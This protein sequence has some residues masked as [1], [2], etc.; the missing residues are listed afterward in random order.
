MATLIHTG[1]WHLGR[2]LHGVRLIEDQAYILDELVA[3]VERVKPDAL[4]IAGDVYDRSVPPAEAVRLL[5]HFLERVVRDLDTRVV[6]ISGNH[7][8]AERIGFGA[9]ILESGK[10]HMRGPLTDPIA[11][12]TIEDEHG[13]LDLFPLPF[14]EPARVRDVLNEET[15]IDHPSAMAAMLRRIL[16]T[17]ADRRRVLIAHAFVSGGLVSDSER[18]LTIGG[19]ETVDTQL[20]DDFQYVA[21]GHLHRPQR[22][23]HDRIQY[24]G[25][26]LKYSF[27]EVDQPKSVS[28]VHIDAQGDVRIE[29]E[30]LPIRRD[31]RRIRGTLQQLLD[32]P[33]PGD[34]NDYLVISLEDQGPVFDAMARLREVYP[35]ALHIERPELAAEGTVSLPGDARN[36]LEIDENELFSAFFKEVTEEELSDEERTVFTT[37]LE[38]IQREDCA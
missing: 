6:V 9:G 2:V 16:E 3:L 31:V 30:T 7:D 12:V 20:F 33:A 23:G 11:P 18:P 26:L 15:V 27:S 36:H 13:L 37:I 38:R 14:L 22:V 21:L 10:L 19:V 5:D 34:H 4:I 8:S 28:V 25:S 17:A 35:N 29:R 32:Q 1:D 24:A